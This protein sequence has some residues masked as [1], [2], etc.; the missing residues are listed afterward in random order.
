MATITPTKSDDNKRIVWENITENDTAD[1]ILIASGK[2]TVEFN[3][4]FG[5]ATGTL[6][7]GNTSG[8][9]VDIDADAAPDGL[10]FAAQGMSNL[11]IAGGFVAP[12]FS[13]GSSQSITVTIVKID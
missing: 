12:D 7:G 5:G 8:D 9:L 4:T 3:G 10:S 2:H 6:Q 13:G 1:P 11:E